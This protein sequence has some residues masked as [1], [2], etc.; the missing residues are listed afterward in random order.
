MKRGKA[1]FEHHYQAN[2]V[3]TGLLWLSIDTEAN[4][5][6]KARLNLGLCALCNNCLLRTMMVIYG[7]YRRNALPSLALIVYRII[8]IQASELRADPS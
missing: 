3:K 4:G 8:R 7:R 6:T 2:E 5:I 1:L